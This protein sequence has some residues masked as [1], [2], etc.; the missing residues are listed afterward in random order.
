MR[1]RLRVT[2]A[3]VKTFTSDIS[4]TGFAAELMKILAPG[5]MQQGT[6]ELFGKT[7]DFT[8]LIRWMK[9]GD[10]RMSIRGRVG[11]QFTGIPNGFYELLKTAYPAH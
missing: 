1:R 10:P 7:F 5:S 6:I 4:P 11:V 3:G 2:L 8:G 9:H